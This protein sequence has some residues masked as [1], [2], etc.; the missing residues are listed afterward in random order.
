MTRGWTDMGIHR[1]GTA[2][3]V[4]PKKSGGA[5]PTTVAAMPLISST[6]PRAPGPRANSRFQKASLRTMTGDA[7]GRSGDAVDFEHLAEGPGAARKFAVPE[8]VAEDDDGRRGR[9]IVVFG[10]DAAG[11]RGDSED[12]EVVAGYDGD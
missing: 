7:A 5:T 6:W 9:P 11:A 3:T 4:S 2:P 1:S 8:G 12:A 10:E